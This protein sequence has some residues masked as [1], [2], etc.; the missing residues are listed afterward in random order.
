MLKRTDF[1]NDRVDAGDLGSGH[2]VTAIYEFVPADSPDRLTPPLRYG[3]QKAAK[4]GRASDEYAFVK[5]RAK[6]PGAKDSFEAA[7]PVGP[8]NELPAL[9]RAADDLRFSVAVAGFA[10]LLRG[11]LTVDADAWDSAIALADAARGADP[12]GW[13]AEA[14][15]LMRA[16]KGL[17]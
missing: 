4:A 17:R 6:R 7:W 12:H 16:A 9:G 2:S 10:Q 3:K 13:R 5:L 11:D 8:A 14:V 15:Q 1:A